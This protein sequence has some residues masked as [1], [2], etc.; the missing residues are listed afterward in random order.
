MIA[1]PRRLSPMIGAL[2]VV[3]LL[4]SIAAALD[5]RDGG[6]L[7]RTLAL[8]PAR[9]WSGEVWRLVTWTLVESNPWA[10]LSGC[11][12]LYWFGGDL[13]EVW[14]P[15]KLGAFLAA[16]VLLAAVGTTVIAGLLPPVARFAHL[17]GWALTDALVVTW[18]LQFPDQPIRVYGILEI[19]GPQLA[20]GVVGFTVLCAI[21]YGIGAFLPELIAGFAALSFPTPSPRRT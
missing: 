17:G 1:T 19:R 21:F 13:E 8:V 11:V 14:G 5:A 20:Y 7:Y 18:A 6:S 9:V 16:I 15:R 12:A 10:L 3:T 4:T 2:I